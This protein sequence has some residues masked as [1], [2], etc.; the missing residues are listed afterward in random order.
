MIELEYQ[1]SRPRLQSA[2]VFGMGVSRKSP[3]LGHESSLQRVAIEY[4]DDDSY[5]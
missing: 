2:M 3:V 4:G 1:G 5:I